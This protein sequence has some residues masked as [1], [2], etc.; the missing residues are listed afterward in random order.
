MRKA[1]LSPDRP[2]RRT[3]IN[4]GAFINALT[5]SCSFLFGDS[6]KKAFA[7]SLPTDVSAETDDVLF[8]AA[9]AEIIGNSLLYSKRCHTLVSGGVS[10]DM[11]FISGRELS[12]ILPHMISAAKQKMT[13]VCPFVSESQGS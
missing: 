7:V 5:V 10:G 9:A 13:A 1:Y 3:R 12:A 4:V 11:L 6:D 2:K 8:S